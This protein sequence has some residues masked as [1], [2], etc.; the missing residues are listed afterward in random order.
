[1]IHEFWTKCQLLPKNV[2]TQILQS[3]Y[4]CIPTLAGG[5]KDNDILVWDMR[6]PGTLYAVLNRTVETNQRIY[7]D[8]DSNGKYVISGNTNGSVTV[9]DLEKTP[10]E[11]DKIISPNSHLTDFHQDA[12]NGCSVHPW[13][14]MIGTCSGQRHVHCPMLTDDND[15]KEEIKMEN[16][17]KIWSF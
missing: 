2:I 1:M 16:S 14:P 10:N 3:L 8:I 15:T 13:L 11:D 12:V 9:W 5:R 6:Q 7:F 17:L 4:N